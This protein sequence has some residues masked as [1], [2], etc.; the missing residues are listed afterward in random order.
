MLIRVF[1]PTTSRLSSVSL[2][3]NSNAGDLLKG[4]WAKQRFYFEDERIKFSQLS[5]RSLVSGL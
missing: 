2:G 3:S 1:T 5:L 4:L